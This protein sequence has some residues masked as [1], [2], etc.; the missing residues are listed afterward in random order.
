MNQHDVLAYARVALPHL[1]SLVSLNRLEMENLSTRIVQDVT[2]GKSLFIFGSGH[3][4]LLPLELYHRAGG[5]SFVIP[6]VLEAL[7]PCAGPPLV[8]ILERT[9]G[10]AKM[11]LSRG[12]PQPGEMIWIMSQ[13]GINAA[14]IDMALEAKK[15]GLYSVAF[16]SLTHSRAVA[17]RHSSG[18]KLFE[19]CDAVMDLGGVVG[20]AAV[21]VSAATG[22]AVGPLSSLGAIFLAHSILAP[23]MSQV[24]GRGVRCV[25]TSVNTP[26][27][28][29]R[30]R[31]LEEVAKVRDPLLR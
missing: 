12:Q 7:L 14:G 21:P 29:L 5:P 31:K 8:R 23:A 19:V 6:L 30:N 18:K 1:E 27:G 24:E 9:E 16:T 11:I 28:E 13:S 10:C 25:Y 22:V 17:S 15:R 20:D 26:E 2:A 3:S 4:A